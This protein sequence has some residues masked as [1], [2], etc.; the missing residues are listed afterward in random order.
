[1]CENVAGKSRMFRK[2]AVRLLGLLFYEERVLRSWYRINEQFLS[3]S[4]VSLTP[5]LSD[6]EDHVRGD[7]PT[8]MP[9][10]RHERSWGCWEFSL[11]AEAQKT[12]GPP[13]F[14]FQT[15]R[16]YQV[17]T[18]FYPSDLDLIGV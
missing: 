13:A 15:I 12:P 17:G 4:F 3:P 6:I 16:F 2:G 7:I 5:L 14:V 1:M 10:W 8:S 18:R 11:Q 9:A